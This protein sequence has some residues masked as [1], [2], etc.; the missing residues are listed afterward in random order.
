MFATMLSMPSLS[1]RKTSLA[2]LLSLAAVLSF[3]YGLSL[4]REIASDPGILTAVA[5]SGGAQ[6]YKMF[7]KL[8]SVPGESSDSV[9]KGEIEVDSFTWGETRNAGATRPNMD[10]L[11]VTMPANKA[12]PRLFLYTAGGLKITRAVL[13]VRKSGSND[14]FLKWTLID[15][16][17]VS[18]K[19]VG[20]IH[21]DGVMDQV[22]FNPGKIE[23]EYKPADGSAIVKAGWDLRTGKSVGY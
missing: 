22:V 1:F 13:S 19:T 23:V 20:N 6:G 12:S 14:D 17:P 11:T 8:D 21:G 4:D 2:L 10:G 5:Q 3:I 7:L 15:A 9:H 16:L 18:F